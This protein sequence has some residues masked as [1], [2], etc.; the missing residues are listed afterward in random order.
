MK[1]THL[2][3]VVVNE[4]RWSSFKRTANNRRRFDK[5]WQLMTGYGNIAKT[6]QDS[7][8]VK[9]V[10][11]LIPE[12]KTK[13]CSA[14][15]MTYRAWFYRADPQSIGGQFGTLSGFLRNT[16]RKRKSQ[17]SPE[18]YLRPKSFRTIFEKRTPIYSLATPHLGLAKSIDYGFCSVIQSTFDY[19]I[20]AQ[21]ECWI[22][23]FTN[24]LF[25]QQTESIFQ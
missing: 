11:S 20:E 6:K 16:F 4:R 9:Y 15:R 25:N 14:S 5:S 22:I 10:F 19:W 21:F 3:F 2:N 24:G 23:H 1:I 12:K 8:W 13:L 18:I 17:K 7:S